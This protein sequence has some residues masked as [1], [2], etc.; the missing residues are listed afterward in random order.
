MDKSVARKHWSKGAGDIQLPTRV[1]VA[2][3]EAPSGYDDYLLLLQQRNRLMKK[4]TQKDDKQIELEKREQGFALYL[5]GAN[6]DTRVL[7][8]T[9]KTPCMTATKTPRSCRKPKTA[10][11]VPRNNFVDRC[12]LFDL[13]D[14]GTIDNFRAKTA[15]SK[16]RRKNWQQHS[17]EIKT[18]RG[19]R[20]RLHA[21]VSYHYSEDFEDGDDLVDSLDDGIDS[22]DYD[23]DFYD[24]DKDD[25]QQADKNYVMLSVDDVIKLRQSLE[26]NCQIRDSISKYKTKSASE[27]IPE[28]TQSLEEDIEEDLQADSLECSTMLAP[29]DLF[30]LELGSK[31]K[32]NEQNSTTRARYEE[33]DYIMLQS[34]PP[35]T[36]LKGNNEAMSL[37]SQNKTNRLSLDVD[38][39]LKAD[40]VIAAI[41]AENEGLKKLHKQIPSIPETSV[42]KSTES[43]NS[44]LTDDRLEDIVKKVS[45][46]DSK[47]Q[48]KLVETLHAIEDSANTDSKL[49][50]QHT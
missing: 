42:D 26:L 22:I 25:G 6:A 17:I 21:P 36:K 1:Q 45:E 18:D 13:E 19:E 8:P 2:K 10:G 50:P 31:G 39:S 41:R 11:D 47:S 29:D 3:Q 33:S 4:L 44:T 30:I 37:R 32:T 20:R 40:A 15:P 27:A 7:P 23:D 34:E 28:C 24:T 16:V 9:S 35:K 14:D 12:S 43:L 48:H 49:S 5:N 38:N 46:L